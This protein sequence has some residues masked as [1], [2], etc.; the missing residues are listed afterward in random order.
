METPGGKTKQVYD[1]TEKG[2]ALFNR[3]QEETDLAIHSIEGLKDQHNNMPLLQ[4]IKHVYLEYPE[5]AVNSKL[6]I[7]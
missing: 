6:D 7:V 1:I 2:E 5:M 4:L 3:L